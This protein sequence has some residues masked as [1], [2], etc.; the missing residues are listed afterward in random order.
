MEN[1]YNV[2]S[3]LAYSLKVYCVLTKEELIQYEKKWVL[4]LEELSTLMKETLARQLWCI[5]KI[6]L[7]EFSV[8]RH[9]MI[10]ME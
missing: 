2:I 10:I 8:L 1:S 3:I 9:A 4:I 5:T 6:R 7:S